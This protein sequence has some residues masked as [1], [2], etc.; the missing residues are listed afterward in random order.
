MEK[1]KMW[2]KYGNKRGSKTIKMDFVINKQGGFDFEKTF[3]KAFKLLTEEVNEEVEVTK[4]ELII[5][6]NKE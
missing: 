3:E 5:E 6:I 2:Y 1:V 4:W